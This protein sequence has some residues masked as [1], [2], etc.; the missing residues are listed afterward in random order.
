[1]SPLLYFLYPFAFLFFVAGFYAWMTQYIHQFKIPFIAN[2]RKNFV[3]GFSFVTLI[4]LITITRLDEN[5]WIKQLYPEFV[6][7]LIIFI[8]FYGVT[9][10]E[11]KR[12]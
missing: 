12:I 6:G 10:I 5:D 3:Y 11:K 4:L 2:N 9:D 8:L 7:T 1:M